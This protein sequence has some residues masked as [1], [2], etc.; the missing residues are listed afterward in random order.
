MCEVWVSNKKEIDGTIG[1]TFDEAK[2][3]KMAEEFI[4]NSNIMDIDD[5]ELQYAGVA[6]SVQTENGVEDLSYALCYTKKCLDNME[7]YGVGP[8][9]KIEIASDYSISG[10]T[11]INKEIVKSVVKYDTLAE[12][13]VIKKICDGNDVQIDGISEG[14]ELD[15]AIDD[16][17]ICFYSDP[18]SLEQKYFAPYYVLQGTDAN[19]NEITIVAPAV[20]DESISY[21]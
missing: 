21:K 9:I 13:S 20:E 19:D 14:E 15:V 10:F 3:K 1:T 5:L 6:E 17:N 16:V 7:F 12:D 8:G 2:C 4:V 11:S 18:I